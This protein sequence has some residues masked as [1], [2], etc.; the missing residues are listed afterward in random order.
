LYNVRNMKKE[1]FS[2]AIHN[3]I[4]FARGIYSPIDINKFEKIIS[5]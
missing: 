3:Q 1:Q 2:K 4:D 5:I